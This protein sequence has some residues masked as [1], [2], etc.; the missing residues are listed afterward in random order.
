M[1]DENLMSGEIPISVRIR[2]SLF[3]QSP[4]IKAVDELD[5]WRKLYGLP[6]GAPIED[7]VGALADHQ[8][9]VRRGSYSKVSQKPHERKL[10]NQPWWKPFGGK[11]NTNDEVVRVAILKLEKEMPGA[12]VRFPNPD[13]QIGS[14]RGRGLRIQRTA[15]GYGATI[16]LSCGCSLRRDTKGTDYWSPRLDCDVHNGL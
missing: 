7:I 14:G 3:Q 9:E 15:D 6:S 8:G 16:E 11:P 1:S 4:R 12:T 5:S 10:E 2:K 13:K